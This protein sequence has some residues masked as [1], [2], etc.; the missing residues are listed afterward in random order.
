MKERP[1]FFSEPMVRAILSG[2]KTQTRKVVKRY[3]SDCVGWF[4]DGDGEWA[5]RFLGPCGSPFLKAWRD[6]CPFGSR[7]VDARSSKRRHMGVH[8]MG[9]MPHRADRRSAGALSAPGLLQLPRELA[10][11]RRRGAVDARYPHATLGQP[12]HAGGHWR[13]CES[14]ARHHRKGRNRGR[15][16]PGCTWL[17]ARWVS[18]GRI[19]G[20]LG[21]NKRCWVLGRG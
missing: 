7:G 14:P 10:Q 9:R 12:H 20:P 13:A 3:S 6:K 15:R 8:R 16:S 2:S 17:A 19:R 1:I 5:Q 21:V 4:D 18:H 11:R